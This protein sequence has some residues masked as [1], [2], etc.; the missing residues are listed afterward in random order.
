MP[1]R[2]PF[3]YVKNRERKNRAEQNIA[4]T[5]F[6]QLHGSI[7][8]VLKNGWVDLTDFQVAA[9]IHFC[10]CPIISH[11]SYDLTIERDYTWALYIHGRQVNCENI[12]ITDD[13]LSTV[14]QVKNLFKIIRKA[15]ICPGNPDERFI[16]MISGCKKEVMTTNDGDIV[17]QIVEGCPVNC[18]GI[19]YN[20]TVRATSCTMLVTDGMLYV[21]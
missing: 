6:H 15:T 12:G 16:E 5:T 1:R 2:N 17:A 10:K 21:Q 4:S 14:G 7:K 3:T 9:T 18:S 11:H 13:L 19:E 20:R 8:E